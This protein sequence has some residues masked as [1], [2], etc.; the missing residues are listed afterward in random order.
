[1]VAGQGGDLGF[2]LSLTNPWIVDL[3]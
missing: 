2:P 1:M 3:W